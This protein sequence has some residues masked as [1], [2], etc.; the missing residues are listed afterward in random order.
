MNQPTRPPE[1]SPRPGSIPWGTIARFLIVGAF[2]FGGPLIRFARSLMSGGTVSLPNNLIPILVGV[3]VIAAMIIGVA[4]AFQVGRADQS[5]PTIP[6]IPTM[7]EPPFAPPIAP[8]AQS[9]PPRPAERR[10][11]ERRA[12]DRGFRRA[13]QQEQV[14]LPP[15]P[16][17]DPIIT[18]RAALASAILAVVIAVVAALVY[19]V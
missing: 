12:D 7:A 10:P 18:P 15:S 3:V 6:T 11:T 16:Q 8:P 2:I 9:A 19:L 1:Q 14:P 17:F 13:A 5:A 4:R